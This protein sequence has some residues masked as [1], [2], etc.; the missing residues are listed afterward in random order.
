MEESPELNGLNS[1]LLEIINECKSEEG[2]KKLQ[3]IYDSLN[4][5]NALQVIGL[6]E[7]VKNFLLNLF[8]T[9]RNEMLQ[10]KVAATQEKI[11]TARNEIINIIKEYIFTEDIMKKDAGMEKNIP[12]DLALSINHFLD[13]G[14]GVEFSEKAIKR[15]PIELTDDIKSRAY[16]KARLEMSKGYLDNKISVKQ[17][18]EKTKEQYGQRESDI[19]DKSINLEIEP[20]YGTKEFMEYRIEHIKKCME[21]ML[22]SERFKGRNDISN[23]IDIINK[24]LITYEKTS[25]K[26]DSI[27]RQKNK[28]RNLENLYKL[29]LKIENAL[30]PE[31]ARVWIEKLSVV[32]AYRKDSDFAFLAHALKD[33]EFDPRDMNKLPMQYITQDTI[34]LDGEYGLIY[35]PNAKN[36]FSMSSGK[37]KEWTISKEDFI[38]SR[39]FKGLSI[40]RAY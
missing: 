35:T 31:V 2:T 10:K 3:A 15:Y 40:Y 36:L 28:Y 29:V 38:N 23:G 7:K 16:S 26:D 20:Y 8:P 25:L 32:E 21:N 11:A 19:E 18:I 17:V 30:A 14:L 34:T 22:K 6:R 5:K 27:D 24:I 1:K 12:S 9:Y 4:E 39:I 37:A 33:G 13:V